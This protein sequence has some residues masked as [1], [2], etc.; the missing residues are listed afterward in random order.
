[1]SKVLTL[2][3]EAQINGLKIRFVKTGTKS[4]RIDDV[5]LS[6]GTPPEVPSSSSDIVFNSSSSTSSNANINYLNYQADVITS[7]SN[8][9]GVMGFYLRDGGA[10]INDS[11]NLATELTEITFTVMNSDNIRSARLF[12][13]NSPRGVTVPVN[14]SSTIAFTGLTNI[15]AADD[16]Q[17]AINLRVS[18]TETVTD[19]EQLQFTIS[20]ATAKS[21]GSQFLL[22]NT[23]GASSS[24]AGDINRIE[25]VASKLAFVQQPS[26]NLYAGTIMYPAPA[27]TAKDELENSDLDYNEIVILTLS[28]NLNI[29]LSTTAVNGTAIFEYYL[30]DFLPTGTSYSLTANSNNLNP[31][32]SNSF[33]VLASSSINLSNIPT[34]NCNNN[35]NLVPN[36]DFEEYSQLPNNENPIE[37]ACGWNT[38]RFH[39]KYFH[40]SSTNPNY[41]IPCNFFGGQTCN[42]DIGNGYAGIYYISSNNENNI[43]SSIMVSRLFSPLV[44]GQSYKLSF[45]VSLAEGYSYFSKAIQAYLSPN[46]ISIPVDSGQITI[47]NPQ[48]LFSN[49]TTSTISNGWETLSFTFTSTEGGEEYI[50]LGAFPNVLNEPNTLATDPS[51]NYGNMN[52]GVVNGSFYYIDNVSLIPVSIASFELPENICNSNIINN[53]TIFLSNVSVDGEFSGAGVNFENGNYTFNPLIAGIGNHLISYTYFNDFG[54]PITMTDEINVVTDGIIAEFENLNN[55]V[56]CENS[57]PPVL[58]TTSDNGITGSWNPLTIDTMASGDYTFTPNFGQC[59]SSQSVFTVTIINLLTAEDDDFSSIPINLSTGGTT[60]SVYTN[61]TLNGN[62]VS[63]LNVSSTILST[64]PSMSTLPTINSEGI[65]TIPN[66]YTSGTYVI[67]YK[68]TDNICLNYFDVAS[69]TV[70]ILPKITNCSKIDLGSLCYHSSVMQTTPFTV[71]NNPYNGPNACEYAMIGNVPCNFTNATIELITPLE[72]GCTLNANGTINIPAGTMPFYGESLYRLR[73]IA[74]PSLTSDIFRLNYGIADQVFPANPPIYLN[75]GATPPE[76]YS[77]GSVNVLYSPIVSRINP[78]TNGMCDLINAE[79]DQPNVSNTVSITETTTPENPY[80][81]IDESNGF[82]QFRVPYSSSNP[83]PAPTLPSQAY[84]LTYT[85]CINNTAP[86]LFCNDATVVIHYYYGSNR[87]MQQTKKENN[88][89]IYPNPSADG[90]FTLLFD[91]KINDGIIE[92]YNLL[93]QKVAQDIIQN[94]TEHP[95]NLPKVSGTYII[96]INDGSQ[97]LIKRIIIK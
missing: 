97:Q 52:Q 58:S 19:N 15:I 41:Q 22:P 90:V 92:V 10:S 37:F 60:P 32:I 45:E 4:I 43:I 62:G 91:K 34:P 11:D 53:L 36:G 65:I 94:V 17:L 93:G 38:A 79:V 57:T 59:S 14:G 51:C 63:N 69:V 24:I 39:S 50:Y 33:E 49:S 95:L 25:V 9:V 88:L 20:S 13:G 61:D 5:L 83:P 23:G 26:S 72:N 44:A 96:R 68:L 76:V 47:N 6:A 75:A 3:V 86:L 87:E 81:I 18:F 77:N 85:M 55:L 28:G 21:T 30:F 71:F 64:I 40:S 78:S 31:I 48:M 16:D 29:P 67:E 56:L 8:S 82:V 27:V 84:T 80:Y 46:M 73:S 2:P 35:C 89:I 70:V 66:D 42:E 7:T 74:Y 1:M 12:V 54:C